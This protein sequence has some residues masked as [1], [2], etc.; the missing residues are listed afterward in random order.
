LSILFQK[1]IQDIFD[2]FWKGNALASYP[3]FCSKTTPYFLLVS[4]KKQ[5][6]IPNF[7]Y[8]FLICILFHEKYAEISCNFDIYKPREMS[9]NID[10]IKDPSYWP[11]FYL[12]HNGYCL[13]RNINLMISPRI[14]SPYCAFLFFKTNF[15][16]V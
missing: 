5:A 7:A 15:K 10:G 2:L 11:D 13:K 6:H 8:I 3:A 4:P 16:K 9:Y 14:H 1:I 12:Q